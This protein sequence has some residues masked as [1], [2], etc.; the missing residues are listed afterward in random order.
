MIYSE[1][2]R[3]K[4]ID[5]SHMLKSQE[6]LNHQVNDSHRPSLNIAFALDENYVR[7]MGVL[8]VSLI[9]NNPDCH[10]I[11]H[12]FTDSIR[13]DD[14]AKLSQ[15]AGQYPITIQIYYI[16]A[17][18]VKNLPIAHHVSGAVY[19]R[20]IIPD[21][22]VDHVDRVLYLDSDIICLGQIPNFNDLD[23]HGHAAGVVKDVEHIARM[24]LKRLELIHGIYFN[25]GVMLIDTKKWHADSIT[26]KV[27]ETLQERGSSLSM[28]EQDALNLVLDG[29]STVLPA[30]WNQVYSLGQMTQDPDPGSL[31]IHF[32][33]MIKPW[34][35]SGRHRL[36]N[37]YLNHENNSPWKGSP[38]LPPSGYKEMEYYSRLFFKEGN[39]PAWLYWYFR[40]LK[41]KFL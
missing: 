24:H 16:H 28:L 26:S 20:L 4:N 34:R 1:V 17:D 36:S 15:L 8:M 30:I 39:Y 14:H 21:I 2:I 10:L 33:G 5:I 27:L 9:A 6:V 18:T 3:L 7:F 38:L 23:L 12:V 32:A 40:Y 41:E 13:P 25:A 22:L 37:L 29:K 11:F 35:M 19:Y 31:F